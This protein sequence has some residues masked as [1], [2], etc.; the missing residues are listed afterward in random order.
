MPAN[1][2][3]SDLDMADFDRDIAINL[4]STMVAA[5]EAGMVDIFVSWIIVSTGC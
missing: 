2:P 1:D 5:K 4:T 3:L